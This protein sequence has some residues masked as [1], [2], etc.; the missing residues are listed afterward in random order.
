VLEHRRARNPLIQEASP[1]EHHNDT[2]ATGQITAIHTI[3]IEL[4]EADETPAVIIISWPEKPTVLHP[5]RF[6]DTAAG[7]A[8]LFAEAHTVLAAIRQGGGSEQ[9]SQKEKVL[10]HSCGLS[11]CR[12]GATLGH[13]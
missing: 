10:A 2:L 13:G 7:I 1:N 3:T 4:V 8:R 12:H 5:R 11:H 6:P 9:H